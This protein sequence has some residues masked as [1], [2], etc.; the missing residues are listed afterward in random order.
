MPHLRFAGLLSAV[1][2]SAF[3]VAPATAA[4][5]LNA[6]TVNQAQFA[7]KSKAHAPS[8]ALL[9]RAQVL[10]DRAEFS[11]G[12]ID[13]KSGENARQAI[14]AF[15][16]ARGLR[17]DGKLDQA[18]FAK[19]LETGSE[20][21]LVEYKIAEGDVKGPFTPS[22]PKDLEHMAG[23][24]HLGYGSPLELLSEKFHASEA[25]LQ[26]LNPGQAFDAAGATITVPNVRAP[27]TSGKVVKIEVDKPGKGLRAFGPGGE[28]VAY[29]PASVGSK[30]K[31]APSGTY[32]VRR[33]TF[34]PTYTYDPKFAFKGVKAKEKV[35]IAEGPNNPVGSVWID[36]TKPSYGIHGTAHPETIGKSE[37]HG[38]VR[39]TNWD[40][41]ELAHMVSKGTVVVFLD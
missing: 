21:A 5:T 25:L 11:P 29:Y 34:N 7:P 1:C 36:L 16:K 28:L 24:D 37:S 18:T 31:P 40:A 2:L 8:S 30:E 26:A 3:C 10:L 13:G 32:G 19:L 9:L 17:A 12:V 4:E 20:P 14:A 15:Q 39:L 38:C 6:A 41:T 22:I 35:E 27:R 33:A 23:L